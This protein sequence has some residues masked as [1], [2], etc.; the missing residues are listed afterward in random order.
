MIQNYIFLQLQGYSKLHLPARQHM[1]HIS[2]NVQGSLNTHFMNKCIIKGLTPWSHHSPDLNPLDSS[3]QGY[4]QEQ[5]YF[6]E[7][8]SLNS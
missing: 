3:F 2:N 6:S 7:A 8:N 5:V 4:I 1:P